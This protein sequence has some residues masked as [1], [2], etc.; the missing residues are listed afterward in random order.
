MQTGEKTKQKTKN[1]NKKKQNKT[2][3]QWQFIVSLYIKSG[4]VNFWPKG[5]LHRNIYNGNDEW[6]PI[7]SVII[8]LIKKIGRPRSGSPIC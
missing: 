5:E 8:Q 4:V 3:K 7:R 6:S 1:K 2:K